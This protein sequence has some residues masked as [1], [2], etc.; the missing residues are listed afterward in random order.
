MTTQTVTWTIKYS[1]HHKRLIARIQ[2]LN[3]IDKSNHISSQLQ[4]GT[5]DMTLRSKLMSF[6]KSRRAI[7]DQPEIVTNH[8][9]QQ[10]IILSSDDTNKTGHSNEAR[11]NEQEEFV[12]FA[13]SE[14][15]EARANLGNWERAFALWKKAHHLQVTAYGKHSLIVARTLRRRGKRLCK[16]WRSLSCTSWFR[17]V[18]IQKEIN[19]KGSPDNAAILDLANTMVELGHVLHNRLHYAEAMAHFQAALALKEGVL[20]KTHVDVADIFVVIGNAFR[21][22][23]QYKEATLAHGR[24]LS[25]YN[26]AGMPP[27]HPNVVRAERCKKDRTTIALNFWNSA[28]MDDDYGKRTT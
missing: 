10:T 26:K 25:V 23:L 24:A 3:G 9:K 13:L 4:K 20:G 16:D 2:P 6:T 7:S 8:D 12:G 5:R 15:A 27:D 18:Q 22:R 21:Q 14:M 11:N 17:A 1:H 28:M 19:R